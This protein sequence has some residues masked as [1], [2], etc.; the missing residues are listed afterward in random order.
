MPEPSGT[1]EAVVREFLALLERPD[2]EAAVALLHDDIEWRNTG[3]PTFRGRTRVGGMLRDM[4][5]R[6]IGFAARMHH[7]AATDGVVLTDRTDVLRIGRWETS[8]WVRGTFEVV[9][10]RIRLWDDAFSWGDF[11]RGSLVGLVRALRRR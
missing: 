3:M 4:E 2:T 7:A 1:S 9:D 10:G 6:G 5:K 11:T 8:F